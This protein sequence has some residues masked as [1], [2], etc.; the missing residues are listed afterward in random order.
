MVIRH[1][2]RVLAIATGL[3]LLLTGAGCCGGASE[4]DLDGLE[5]MVEAVERASEEQRLTLAASGFAAVATDNRWKVGTCVDAWS[6]YS[7]ASQETRQ[8]LVAEALD[9]CK[10]MC[11]A[12]K[13][14]KT[15]VVATIASQ[16]PREKTQAVVDACD[17]EGPEP[18]FTGD[19]E[20]R[21]GQM[22]LMEF[23]VFRSALDETYQRIDAQG[24]ERERVL[25]GRLE[26]MA[27][28]IGRALVLGLPPLDPD[29]DVPDSTS[30]RSAPRAPSVQV[31]RSAIGVDGAEVVA[32]GPDGRVPGHERGT[33]IAPLADA[34]VPLAE[35]AVA[36]REAR[37]AMF[38]EERA[39]KEPEGPPDAGE[40]AKA[41][42]EEG[43][44]GK[45]DAKLQRAKGTKVQLAKETIDKQIAESAG[46]L[47]DL[48]TLET[49]GSM[50]GIGI[51]GSHSTA[52]GIAPPLLTE[53]ASLEGRS[54]V[55]QCDRSLPY[56]LVYDA[57]HTAY[58]S[59]FGELRLGVWNGD[60]GRQTIVD[61]TLG[62]WNP[63]WAGD[64]DEKPPLFLTIVVTEDGF[65]VKGN[66]AILA[67]GASAAWKPGE[68]TI[69]ARDGEHD[70]DEL[71]RLIVK[72]K[73]EYPDEENV[74]I[75]ADPDVSHEVLVRAADAAREHLPEGAERSELLFPFL[76][77]A[78]KEDAVA[79]WKT[80]PRRAR[81]TKV[82][83][84]RADVDKQIAENAG[85]LG[86]L[87]AMGVSGFEIG[88]LGGYG[89][90]GGY[91]GRKS[92]GTP[93]MSTG[94]PIILGALDK[95]VI[96]RV[97][98]QHSAQIRYCYQKELNKDP[99][100]SGKVV[101]KFT[102][103]ADGTVSSAETNS[104][105]MN[106]ATV[107]DCICNRF[108]RFAFPEPEGGGIV[109]VRYPFT[110]RGD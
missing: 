63:D 56:S 33:P 84:N 54:L 27:E 92:S 50:F 80:D 83:M 105:T 36:E 1:S 61:A 46:I 89:S 9:G 55:V 68:P 94:D 86:D 60:R 49:D 13:G 7:R 57:L 17:E 110:F 41:R 43:K 58:Q 47:A 101:I 66:A 73:A 75:A 39:L 71:A 21:R 67:T 4:A 78:Q 88:S 42:R 31:S 23:W 72:V 45:K 107:E 22:E 52:P 35:Q 8:V 102:I 37:E 10:A 85:V 77:L 16:S 99:E 70:F 69:A 44:V 97:I 19:L 109:I 91:F 24:S 76:L 65:H 26:Q 53:A 38:E 106:N 81:G 15:E 40:G 90:G 74:L 98:K 25:R 11:P 29:L 12:E 95:S 2:L 59:G 79:F 104:T 100:L 20:A 62:H 3:G 28:Q 108:L 34:L 82:Q 32:L 103:A 96:D 87:N 14:K 18:V 51:V 64:P 6:A 93:G 48:N 30:S 5:M